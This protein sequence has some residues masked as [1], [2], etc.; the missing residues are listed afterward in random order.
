VEGK[1]TNAKP[2]ISGNY[3]L[4]GSAWTMNGELL[5]ND[6]T[7]DHRFAIFSTPGNAVI[8]INN[9]RARE[10]CTITKEKTGL[11]A[12]SVDPFT[13]TSRKATG[14]RDSGITLYFPNALNSIDSITTDGTTLSVP[15]VSSAF[16]V[17]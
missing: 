1:K 6:G 8:Y 9:V 4:D 3:Q 7:L 10:A 16:S 15:S 14:R 17:A 11:M 5:T 2:I 13:S 12:I